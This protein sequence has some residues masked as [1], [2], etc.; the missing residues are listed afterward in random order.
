MDH[1]LRTREKK[2]DPNNALFS[3]WVDM[4]ETRNW[5]EY[6]TERLE[7]L[8]AIKKELH[9]EADRL[10]EAFGRKNRSRNSE[11]N[12]NV[13]RLLKRMSDDFQKYHNRFYGSP[14]LQSD[15]L[16]EEIEEME[17]QTKRM[18]AR[19]RAARKAVRKHAA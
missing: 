6:L 15:P 14:L 18:V 12:R 1:K 16:V 7:P 8:N 9:N 3:A 2:I 11:D 19:V 10:I 5:I 17:W 4:S 13:G